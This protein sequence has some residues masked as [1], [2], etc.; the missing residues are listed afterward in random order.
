M[1]RK[2]IHPLHHFQGFRRFSDIN[3]RDGRAGVVGLLLDK[4]QRDPFRQCPGY[5][6]IGMAMDPDAQTVYPDQLPFTNYG[7]KVLIE[8]EVIATETGKYYPSVLMVADVANSYISPSIDDISITL[9]GSA[10]APYSVEN[11]VVEHDMTGL[12]KVNFAFN[13]PSV[14]YAQRPLEGPLTVYIY[15]SG[16][17]IPLMTF[18]NVEPGQA[19]EWIDEQPLNGNNSY[20]VVA[21][22]EYGRGKVSEVSVFAGIDVP[23]AVEN[24]WI[25]GNVD[26]QKAI[27]TWDAPSG[28]VNGGVLDGSLQ[29]TIVE[30]FPDG[31]TPEEQMTVIGTTTETTFTVDREPTNEM[32]IHYYAV[33]PSTSAGIGQAV[34]DEIILGKLKDAPF[35][36]S[37]ADGYLY[38]SGWVGDADVA[39]YGTTWNILTDNNEMAS[40]DGDNGYALCYNGNYYNSYHWADLITP[41]VKVEADKQYTLSF[42]VYMGYSS[43][44]AIAP[45]LVVSQSLNDAP[46]EELMTI[47]VTEGNG[48]WE[49]F[50]IPLTG[51]ELANFMKFSFRGYMSTMSERIWL[52]NISI[53]C[54]E[55]PSGVNELAAKQQIAA[56]KGGISIE[57]FEGQ[58][59]RV[60]T[61]DGRQVST[62]V[63]DGYRT[64]SMAPGIY[65][66]TVGKQ[67]YKIS[68]R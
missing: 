5:A 38:S 6:G 14:D 19:I 28:G 43:S 34:L 46:Y 30:Y 55:K 15:R 1:F 10:F 48:E 20:I 36:E 27:L 39:N 63:A 56:V 37:F 22:N 45:T 57:G 67:A 33:I 42:W 2:D 51:T 29:Y 9:V 8:N 41:K 62:F 7:E 50:E 54:E 13:A 35:T 18:E 11:L 17:A 61:V 49:Q 65:I 32:E 64:L 47:N 60:F 53:T 52:D 23:M 58:Q 31:A 40:Q 24:F 21:E 66:V 4:V 68:V 12:L 16:S 3:P 25:V 44:A 59:V 26:N